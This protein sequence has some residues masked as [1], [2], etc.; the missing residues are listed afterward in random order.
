MTQ[1]SVL[2]LKLLVRTK[3]TDAKNFENFYLSREM[4]INTK[5]GMLCPLVALP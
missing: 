1:F 3:K 2:Y 4:K 5:S